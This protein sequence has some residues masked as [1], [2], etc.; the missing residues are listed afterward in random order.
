MTDLSNSFRPGR[1][2]KKETVQHMEKILR[3]VRGQPIHGILNGQVAKD[4]GIGSDRCST[5][6]RRLEER[7]LVRVQKERG[8]LRYF[9]V[10]EAD[11]VDED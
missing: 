11:H 2:P 7:K 8:A 6:A 5:L 4:V 9:P 1:P 10:V 3:I